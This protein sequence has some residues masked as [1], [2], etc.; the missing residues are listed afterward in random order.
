M[1]GRPC[2]S[3]SSILGYLSPLAPAGPSDTSPEHRS[4]TAAPHRSPRCEGTP[5][6]FEWPPEQP[7]PPWVQGVFLDWVPCGDW[8]PGHLSLDF[9]MSWAWREEVRP[10]WSGG[11]A[12]TAIQGRAR[13]G[14][15]LLPLHLPCRGQAF[16]LRVLRFKI[17]GQVKR[18]LN[19]SEPS[20][21]EATAPAVYRVRA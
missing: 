7:Q 13:G 16:C 18:A 14:G 17:W 8:V 19:C 9:G 15:R 20:F 11:H 12:N 2:G 5:H 10:W 21:R 1:G 4:G 6:P 3:E